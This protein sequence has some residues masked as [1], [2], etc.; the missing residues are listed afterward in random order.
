MREGAK[1]PETAC[2]L[3]QKSPERPK[4]AACPHPPAD[5]RAKPGSCVP[6]SRLYQRVLTP[7][8][9]NP[10]DVVSGSRFCGSET[11]R[12]ISFCHSVGKIF[13][14]PLEHVHQFEPQGY[15]DLQQGLPQGDDPEAGA[16]RLQLH[17]QSVMDV[18][19]NL[20][21]ARQRAGY[22]GDFCNH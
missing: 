7:I 6:A 22:Q 17:R 12:I 3:R 21:T 14:S 1:N 2:G 18:E 5:S 19:V 15:G 16:I 13:A 20:E 10:A 8:L 9:T 11:H 4:A